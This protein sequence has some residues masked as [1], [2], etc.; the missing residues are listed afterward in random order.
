MCRPAVRANYQDQDPSSSSSTPREAVFISPL[1][2]C[3]HQVDR[4]WML[5]RTA[6]AA[7]LGSFCYDDP[8]IVVVLCVDNTGRVTWY[9]SFQRD[10]RDFKQSMLTY[11]FMF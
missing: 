9:F 11:A 8:F 6:C 10:R 3:Q 2:N 5:I 7:R 4:S 1:I